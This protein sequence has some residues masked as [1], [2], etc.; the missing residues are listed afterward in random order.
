MSYF[1]SEISQMPMKCS[2]NEAELAGGSIT[3]CVAPFYRPVASETRLMTT[4]RK[5]FKVRSKHS[6]ILTQPPHENLQPRRGTKWCSRDL[7]VP[8]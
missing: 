1:L 6:V 5:T 4:P 3:G 8:R 7:D 2:T